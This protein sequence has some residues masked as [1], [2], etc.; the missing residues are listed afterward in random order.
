MPGNEY[1]YD[2][3][4]ENCGQTRGAKNGYEPPV[5]QLQLWCRDCE[6]GRLRRR[7]ASVPFRSGALRCGLH[8][9]HCVC[10]PS[11][12]A[13]I[14]QMQNRT[15]PDKKARSGSDHPSEIKNL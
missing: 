7:L 9:G 8:L 2:E 12:K 4:P 6:C 13:F 10:G 3:N 5:L 14:R 1:E 15:K 11:S